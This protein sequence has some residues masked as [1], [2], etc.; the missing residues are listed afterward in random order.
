MPQRLVPGLQSP[1]QRPFSQIE[2]QVSFTAQW[3]ALL[4]VS[5]AGAA[6]AAQRVSPTSHSLATGFVGTGSGSLPASLSE[7]RRR[8]DVEGLV[9]E[10]LPA[11]PCVPA[12]QATTGSRNRVSMRCA[13]QSTES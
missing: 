12:G 3:L 1:A 8:L 13:F 11:I 5:T 10:Q 9:A 4:Q 2:A 7:A 6:C